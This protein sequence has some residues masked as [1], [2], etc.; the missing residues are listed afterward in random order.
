[1]SVN[2][3]KYS[4][5]PQTLALKKGNWWIGTGD[6]SKGPTQITDYW[7]GISPPSGGY[8]VYLPGDQGPNIY[9]PANDG[10]LI[11]LTNQLSSQTF[12]S[13]A[14]ALNWYNTQSDKMVMNIDYPPI[15]TN[16]LFVNLDGGFTPSFP[17]GGT[18]WYDVS[19]NGNN[20]ALINGP[21]YSPMDG[22]AII[23]DGSDDYCNLGTSSSLKFT[24]NFT[25]DVWLKFNT[26]SGIRTIVSNN[27]TGGYGIIANLA[28]TRLETWFYINGVYIKAG[29]D[30][31]NYNTVMWFNITASFDGSNVNFYRNGNLMQ[32]IPVVGTVSI[33]AE[34]LIVGANP[35]VGGTSFIDFFNGQI[36]VF[37]MYNRALASSEVLQNFNAQK[38]RFGL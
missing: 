36:A 21:V 23:F 25:I 22:G 8:S 3:I 16:G 19:G 20:G 33:T 18:A 15:I 37:S 5:I 30:M 34:P 6:V 32:N 29:E 13:G 27:E 28:S 11:A 38:S 9:T 35:Q 1:M 26:L 12:T 31:S 7:A 10:D 17:K 2:G 24:S 14:S 4:P